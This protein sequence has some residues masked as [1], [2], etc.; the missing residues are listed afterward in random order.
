MPAS[1]SSERIPNAD[2]KLSEIFIGGG[3]IMSIT[4]NIK[5]PRKANF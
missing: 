1:I 2:G 3:F 5:N 4:L